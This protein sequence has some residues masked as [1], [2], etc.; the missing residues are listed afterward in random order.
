MLN[1]ELKKRNLPTLKSKE[2]MLSEII[3]T[4]YGALPP[5]PD[6]IECIEKTSPTSSF[7]CGSATLTPVECT[8]EIKGR[9][10]TFPF[11]ASIPKSEGPHPFFVLINFRSYVPDLYL[12]AEEIIDN[13]FAVLSFDYND[14]TLDKNEYESGLCGVLFKNG[15]RKEYDCGKISMWAWAAQRI[16]DWAETKPELDMSRAMVCG[17]SR[18]GKTALV[19]AATDNRFKLAYSNDSGCMGAAISRDKQGERKEVIC[20]VF[21]HWFTPKFNSMSSDESL[22]PFDQHYLLSSISPR[23]VL[24]GSAVEDIWADPESEMLNCVASSPVFE[25]DGVKGF[26]HNNRYAKVGE[27]YFE[28]NI[29]YHLRRGVHYFG[30]EDWHRLMEFAKLKFNIK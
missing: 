10:F 28:G 4:E 8:C 15:E 14:V 2:E 5:K 17:H 19:A 21:P 16:L 3:T 20:R 26:C 13:G 24:V 29:G 6:K 1:A 23:F 9:E 7:C 25:K 18:L 12:P 22:L 27:K 30:R 11:M